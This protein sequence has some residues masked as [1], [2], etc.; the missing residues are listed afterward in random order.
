MSSG[1]AVTI[2]SF[3]DFKLMILLMNV[4]F[5]VALRPVIANFTCSFFHLFKL[6]SM[7]SDTAIGPSFSAN[8]CK[9]LMLFTATRADKLSVPFLPAQFFDIVCPILM[10]YNKYPK[11]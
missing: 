1:P 4:D 7:Y 6:L 8:R 3:S 5:H 10:M 2:P 9:T 11:K